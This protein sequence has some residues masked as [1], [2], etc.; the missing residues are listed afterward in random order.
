[1]VGDSVERLIE[2]TNLAAR[3]P[4]AVTVFTGGTGRV[5]S[6]DLKEADFV[7]PILQKLGMD[8]RETIFENQS[9]NT[10]ENAM[11][12]KPIVNPPPDSNWIL[13][14]SAAHMPRSV[15]VFRK[16]NWPG[17][18]PYPVDFNTQPAHALTPPFS[19]TRGLKGLANAA[20]EYVGLLSYYATGKT[21]DL[22]PAPN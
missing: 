10:Y 8:T 7:E 17:L 15:G 21:D 5:F 22:F 14:T 4:E 3:Y 18:I 11:L 9:R 6:Q 2:F 1:M 20:T 13:V 16:V 19:L 12:S